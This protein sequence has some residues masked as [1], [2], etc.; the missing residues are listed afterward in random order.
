M[1]NRRMLNKTVVESDPF[2]EMP[3]DSQ[4]NAKQDTAK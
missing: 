4:A 1:A 2:F 3:A